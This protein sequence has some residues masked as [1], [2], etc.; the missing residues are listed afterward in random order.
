MTWQ[1]PDRS[2]MRLP[3]APHDRFA[4]K[5]ISWQQWRVTPIVSKPPADRDGESAALPTSLQN[6]TAPAPLTGALG[7][8]AH[9]TA[10]RSRERTRARRRSA[11]SEQRRLRRCPRP[12][13]GRRRRSSRSRERRQVLCR[14]CRSTTRHCTIVASGSFASLRSNVCSLTPA[15]RASASAT[16][17]AKSMPFV[18]KISNAWP[19]SSLASIR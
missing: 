1:R 7:L 15:R 9:S 5:S 12:E 2:R 6:F 14:W 16:A 10:R 13:R 19:S 4:Q 18:E 8:T 3:A 17:S 11:E